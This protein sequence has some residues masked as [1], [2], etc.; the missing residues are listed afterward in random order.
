MSTSKKPTRSGDSGSR[1]SFIKNSALIA[2]GITIVP[3][4]VLGGKGFVPPSDT[5]YAAGIGVGGKGEVD[6]KGI[7]DCKNAKVIA[8]CD[9]DDQSA[10]K[11]VK[12]FPGATYYKDWRIMLDKEGKNLDGVSVTT[13]D[14]MHAHPALRAMSMGKHVYVQKPLTHNIYEARLLTQAAEKYK[15]ATQMGNQ[16]GS[17]DDVRTVKEWVDAGMIGD[18]TR[19]HSWTNR[20]V[21][22]QGLP[23]PKGKF[24]VPK[25][26]D[27]D[28]WIGCADF[29]DYNPAYHPFNWRGWWPYGTGALGDMACHILDP[30]FRI[31]PV[32]YAS[33]VECSA[34]TIWSDFFVEADYPDSCPP[35]SIIHF[36]FPRTDGKGDIRLTWMDGGLRPERPLELLPD[37]EMGDVDGGLIM[38]GTK[39]KIITGMWGRKPRLLPSSRMKTE[40]FPAETIPRIPKGV[41]GHY[42]NWVDAA[43]AG[44]GRGVPSSPFNY[45]GPFTEAILLGNVALRAYQIKGG[46]GYPGRKKLLWDAENMKVTN[47]DEANQFV[48]R[49]YRKG[50]E[51]VG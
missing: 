48:K 47:F 22:P 5:F 11:S 28:L 37:E 46:K 16:G 32:K 49:T 14:H 26:L 40:T 36:T 31:L 8:L 21:W 3:R 18:V 41:D 33:D 43:M 44:Y 51:L 23:T 38:E 4:F 34:S 6:M 17:G 1:R 30:F 7:G 24:D 25:A 35:S 29:V 13:P 10:E 9:V 19:V 2:S 20:P 15:V 45:S 12:R 39:G 42:A 50:W 27:W